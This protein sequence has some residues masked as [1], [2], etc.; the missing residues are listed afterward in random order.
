MTRVL[1]RR[2]EDTQRQ[3]RGAVRVKMEAETG[4]PRVQ[5]E[6]CHESPETARGREGCSSRAVRKHSRAETLISG[7]WPPEL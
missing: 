3:H 4:V 2:G 1:T 7:F 6:E 5:A